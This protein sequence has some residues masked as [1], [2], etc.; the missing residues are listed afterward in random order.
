MDKRITPTLALVIAGGLAA[1]IGLARPSTSNT[2]AATS[3]GSEAAAQPV[4]GSGSGYGQ[5]ATDQQADAALTPAPAATNVVIKDF[6]FSSG[7]VA[8]AGQAVTVTNN[9]SASHTLTFDSGEVDTGS[10]G[11]GQ[12]VTFNAPTAPGAYTFFCSIHPSMEGQLVV[13]G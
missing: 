10:L 2:T 13:Q 8:A 5:P 11:Q 3:N 4:T 7:A 1:G 12:S 9:D 6:A